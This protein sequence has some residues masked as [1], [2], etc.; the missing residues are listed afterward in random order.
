MPAV[1]VAPDVMRP[2]YTASSPFER[3]GRWSDP[4]IVEEAVASIPA[5]YI[6]EVVADERANGCVQASYEYRV[7]P[8]SETCDFVIERFERVVIELT[9]VVPTE[10][11][12][13][14]RVLSDV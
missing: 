9:D 5:K 8:K 14:V 2:L 12:P 11:F 7:E 4:E 13:F 3:D 10:I 6:V 1:V